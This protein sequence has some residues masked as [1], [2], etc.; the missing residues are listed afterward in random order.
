MAARRPDGGFVSLQDFRRIVG[1]SGASLNTML[2]DISTRKAFLQTQATAM[3]Q[4][5]KAMPTTQN[6]CPNLNPCGP[7][8]DT[9]N[10]KPQ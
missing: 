4:T 3:A 7:P 1:A 10:G 2:E 6:L 5:L 9:N 8:D